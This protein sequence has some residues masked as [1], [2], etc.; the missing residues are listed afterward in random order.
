MS[1]A[2][3][4]LGPVRIA[5]FVAVGDFK[6][7]LFPVDFIKNRLFEPQLSFPFR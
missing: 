7:A 3:L 4:A 5:A 2:I 6:P 1:N